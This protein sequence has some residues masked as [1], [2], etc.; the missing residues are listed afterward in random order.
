M[1][2][3]PD[4]DHEEVPGRPAVSPENTRE[5]AQEGREQ[6]AEEGRGDLTTRV[7]LFFERLFGRRW[8][9]TRGF[10]GVSAEGRRE[11]TAVYDGWWRCETLEDV[12][13]QRLVDRWAERNPGMVDQSDAAIARKRLKMVR[14]SMERYGKPW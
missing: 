4:H 6:R 5:Q 9:T 2:E 1:G 12:E 3:N 10:S 11:R 13:E 7:R 14:R 8:A